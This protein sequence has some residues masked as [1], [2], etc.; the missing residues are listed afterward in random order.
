MSTGIPISKPTAQFKKARAS[1]DARFDGLFFVGVTT[2]GIYCRP[3]CPAPTAKE[4]NVEYYGQAW[5]A[6]EAG[7]RPC[8][9]CRPDA[10]PASPAWKGT[11]TSFYRA[12]KLIDNGALEQQSLEQLAE[13]LGM[14][15]RYLRKLFQD[16]LG[17]A[18]LAYSHHRKCEFAKQLLQNSQ[19]KISD[20]A[21]ASGF[22]SLRQFN[23]HFKNYTKL[24]PRDVRRGKLSSQANELEL[25]LYYR[26]PYNWSRLHDFLEHRLLHDVEWLD[27]NHYGRRIQWEDTLGEFT[28][29]HQADKHRFVIKL[30]LNRLDKLHHIVKNIRRVLDLDANSEAIFQ[31]LQNSLGKE[32]KLGKA[33]IPGLRLPGIWNSFEAGV[34][35]IIG[36]QITV[37]AARTQL[38]Y[39]IKGCGQ[40]T[41]HNGFY[42]PT[43]KDIQGN[44][45]NCL[46]MPGARKESLRQLARY[47]ALQTHDPAQQDIH[48]DDWLAIK[49]IGPWTVNYA[50]M[51][52]LSHPDIFISGDLGIKKAMDIYGE[53][54]DPSQCSPWQSYL[55]MQM[56]SNL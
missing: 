55:N 14:G 2:T 41:G 46:K 4:E 21:M 56:W 15:S 16:K 12:L 53:A 5:Q 34:R 38:G 11:D 44:A 6:Q 50:N 39:L 43:P 48:D 9:R 28:A 36:Q 1:R 23:Q 7:Y 40:A 20:V 51:R 10:S 37:V 17:I 24:T 26:P 27:E 47:Y 13:R 54:L 29:H 30:K 49:G 52:G 42:F 35:A 25:P 22:G 19:L 32:S 45:L 18:P 33:L 8:L 31:H 3:I